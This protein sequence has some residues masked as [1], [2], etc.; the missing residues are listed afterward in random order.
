MTIQIGDSLPNISLKHVTAGG[1]QDVDTG[2]LFKGKTVALFAVP[3]A[4]TPTCTTIHL[5][6]F[7]RKM[8][9]F[10]SKGVS[11]MC[12]SVNDPFVM[13]AWR[14][15]TNA[16]PDISFLADWNA[17][18]TEAVGL[19]LDGS[20]AGLGLRSLRYGMVVKDGIVTALHVEENPS[21][22]DVS[23]SDSLLQS[24]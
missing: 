7:S 18:F 3:G 14:K 22:C 2:S 8:A 4:F 12:L 13:E 10:Q 6:G 17:E 15:S 19:T 20:G 9:Q 1:I 23:S 5:P 16:D 21:K 11:V 24:L